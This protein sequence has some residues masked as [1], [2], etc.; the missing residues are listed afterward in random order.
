[1]SESILSHFPPMGVYETLF[2]FQAA[3]GKYMGTEGTHP[4]AQG[5]PVTIQLPGGPAIPSSVSFQPTDLKYPPATGGPELLNA[6]SKYYNTFYGANITADNVAIFAGGRPGIYAILSFL[7]NDVKVLVEEAEYTPYWDVL[8]LMKR[9]YVVVPSN[10]SNQFRPSLK[11]YQTAKE[12]AGGRVMVLKSNPCNP[13]GVVWSG[14]QLR[15]LVAFCEAPGSAAIM[16][17]AYEFFQT[18]GHDSAMRYIKD[19]DN[20]NIFV[21]GAATKGLQ[22]PGLRVGWVISS[23]KNIELFRNYSSLAMGGVSRPSQILVA[24]MLEPARVELSRKAIAVFYGKQRDRYGA[25]LKELG[26][27]L[28]TGTGGFYH[29]VKLPNNLT[30]AEFNKRL[31]QHNAGVLPGTL[32]DMLRRG[33]SSP[34]ATFIR[35]SFGPLL[36]DSF[37]KDMAIIKAC[38]KPQGKL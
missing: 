30:A 37:E 24:T 10:E 32:V 23:K 14:D 11:D 38:V 12:K 5:F 7:Q 31:F 33:A 1:M 4:W 22:V 13:T 19:L 15:D 16:D 2:A 18:S 9:D 6:V 17:E 26:F 3:T 36:P 27:I 35:F 28:Y 34:L 25:A 29:W 8:K 20:T 21:V